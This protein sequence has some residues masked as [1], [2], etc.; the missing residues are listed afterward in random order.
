[1][2]WGGWGERKRERALY[3]FFSLRG[4]RLKGRERE[5]WEKGVLGARETRGAREE[6]GS[7]RFSLSLPFQTPATQ[8]IFFFDYCYFL[9]DT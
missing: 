9:R 3:I 8:A 1:M 6:G 2:L 7:L 5:F 4:R